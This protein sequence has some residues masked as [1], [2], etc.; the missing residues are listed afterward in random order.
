MM[1]PVLHFTAR[2]LLFAICVDSTSKCEWTVN[3]IIR[4]GSR[5]RRSASHSLK[6]LPITP[7]YSPSVVWSQSR[8]F[9]PNFRYHGNGGRSDVNF[10]GT[11]EIPNLWNPLLSLILRQ[12]I[13]SG[14]LPSQ[15]V[16]PVFKKGG[17]ADPANYKPVSLIVTYIACNNNILGEANHGFRPQGKSL[18]WDSAAGDFSYDL[19][20]YVDR[21][22]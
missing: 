2:L 16:T 3:T 21:G 4:A 1:M 14:K 20:K 19:L 10:N 8:R 17:R 6:S 5:I 18:Y 9:G 12:F 11:V 13:Q 22:E 15:W 7:F